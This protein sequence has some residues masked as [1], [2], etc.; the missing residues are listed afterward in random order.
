V[1]SS[2]RGLLVWYGS[3]IGDWWFA[4]AKPSYTLTLRF[5]NFQ[6]RAHKYCLSTG[7]LS[8]GAVR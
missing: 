5:Q 2:K 6:Q 8:F 1:D 3:L 7:Q 4:G